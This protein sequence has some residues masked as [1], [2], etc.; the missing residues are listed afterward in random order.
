MAL[1]SVQF[2]IPEG[3]S[4]IVGPNGSG[5]TT[6][7][8]VL[9]IVGAAWRIG[10]VQALEQ[11][12]GAPLLR[13]LGVPVTSMTGIVLEIADL[14][15]SYFP[16]AQGGAIR[17]WADELLTL[18][19]T[20]I[21]VRA[22]EQ[23]GN[24]NY[25]PAGLSAGHQQIPPNNRLAVRAAYDVNPDDPNIGV[26]R[27]FVEGYS[28]YAPDRFDVSTLMRAGSQASSDVALHW[29]GLN[30]FTVLR[31]WHSHRSYRARHRFVVDGL[32]DLFADEVA[33]IDFEPAIHSTV[34]RVYSPKFG[35]IPIPYAYASTGFRFALLNLMGVASSPRGGIVAIDDPETALHPAAIHAFLKR[36]EDYAADNDLRIVFA[37]HSPVVLDYF[38]DE[39]ERVFAM[40][41]G[42][43]TAPTRL[44]DLQD[45]EWLK[46]FS[47]GGLYSDLE[48]GAPSKRSTS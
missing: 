19:A 16:M 5:K 42:R 32:K 29:S 37:T 35:D 13:T 4:V 21:V 1:G 46:Q 15:W 44:T 26:F 22:P 27:N 31:N 17:S 41:T 6:L 9:E 33:D 23:A 34:L 12:V 39:P 28:Y 40:E 18:G 20:P 3:L 38:R 8:R 10:P 25:N 45:A 30:A 11:L 48:F 47:L 43:A 14:R 7:L 36:V 24:V 2:E